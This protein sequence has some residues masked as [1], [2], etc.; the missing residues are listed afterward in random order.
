[1]KSKFGCVI[2]GF[3]FM[4]LVMFIGGIIIML[5]PAEYEYPVYHTDYNNDLD[6]YYNYN[7]LYINT[8]IG[9]FMTIL[10]FFGFLISCCVACA[11]RPEKTQ[12]QVQVQQQIQQSE[13]LVQQP[14]MIQYAV[15]QNYQQPQFQYMPTIPMVKIM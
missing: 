2:T 10:G 11:I 3:C 6:Y 15:Q 13:Q 8:G 5:V 12:V 14:P 1:M 7:Y 9:L 4:F